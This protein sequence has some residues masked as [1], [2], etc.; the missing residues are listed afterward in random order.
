MAQQIPCATD[1]YVLAPCPNT[2]AAPKIGS[3]SSYPR[4]DCGVSHEFRRIFNSNKDRAGLSDRA[5]APTH[6]PPPPHA[7]LTNG[8]VLPRYIVQTPIPCPSS[9]LCPRHQKICRIIYITCLDITAWNEYKLDNSDLALTR[10]G[11]AAAC[12]SR[13]IPVLVRQ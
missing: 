12:E 11:R 8:A 2:A 1:D 10:L 4:R 13:Q 5:S 7:T 9:P 6:S 3:T